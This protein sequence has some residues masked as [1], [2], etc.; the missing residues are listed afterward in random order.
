MWKLPQRL[1]GNETSKD[2]WDALKTLFG[3]QNRANVVFLKKEFRRMHKGGLKMSEYLK[4]MKKIA[5]NLA[6]TGKPVDD[7]DLVSQVLAGL[8]SLEYNPVVCQLNE[9]EHVSWM[10]LQST[11]LSYE[12]RLK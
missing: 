7:D 1:W 11:L 2:L 4:A 12:R 9:K 8:D 5:D 3:V 6:L 10:E